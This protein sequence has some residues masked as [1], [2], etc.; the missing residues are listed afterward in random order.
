MNEVITVTA[1]DEV[2]IRVE[3]SDRGIEQELADHFTF[4]VPGYKFMPSYRMGGWDGK[5]RLY[6]RRTKLLYKGLLNEVKR[7]GE[8]KNYV[9]EV[10]LPD[11]PQ[12]IPDLQ[13]FA[14]TLKI[15]RDIVPRDYQIEAV[16]ACIENNRMTV[17]APT[18]SGKSLQIYLVT[19]FYNKKTLII[20]PTINLVHQMAHDFMEYGYPEEIHKIT[21]GVEKKTPHKVTISTWQSIY[22]MPATY[23][24]QFDVV[25]GDEVHQFKSQSLTTIMCKLKKCKYRF[26]FTGTLDETKTH[27]TVIQGLF[28]PK[29]QVTRTKDLI[30]NQTLASFSIK[31]MLLE[32]P[33][34]HRKFVKDFNYQQEIDFIVDNPKRNELI[35]T[36]TTG[37]K[38]NTLVLFNYIRHGKQLHQLISQQTQRPVFYVSGEVEGEVREQIRKVVETESD[39]IIVASIGVFSTGINIVSLKNIIFASPSKSRIRVLQSIG[40]VLRKSNTKT[41]AVLIDIADDLSW[42]KHKNFTYTHYLARL[43]IYAQEQFPYKV[44]KVKI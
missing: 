34:T 20:V 38:G 24:D 39:A 42:K 14:K 9:L 29:L 13:E 27:E 6:D 40:R 32:Y 12:T 36:I 3:A 25:I 1:I 2:Y 5:I 37:L 41:E 8:S 31:S 43:K 22:K 28:G 35:T 11:Q 21:A 44:I 26:G 4:M 16:R 17:I 10:H 19:R 33:D 18:A 30:D 15:G 23:F 7:F